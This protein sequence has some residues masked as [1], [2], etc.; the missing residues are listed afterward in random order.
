[1]NWGGPAMSLAPEHRRSKRSAAKKR[2]SLVFH[3]SEHP[4]RFPCLIVDSSQN[5]FRLHLGFH[6]RRGQVVEVVPHDD[7]SNWVPCRVIWAGKLGSK[8]EHEVGLE[9]AVTQPQAVRVYDRTTTTP[10]SLAAK[11]FTNPCGA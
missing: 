8:Q 7:P 5:G 9:F 1:M 3:F 11:P 2:A 4:G 6:L 10:E